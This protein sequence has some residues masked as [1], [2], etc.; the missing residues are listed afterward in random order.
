MKKQQLSFIGD[1]LTVSYPSIGKTFV[2]D[3]SKYPASVYVRCDSSE[4]GIKQKFGDAKSGGTAAEKYAEVQLIH[5]SLLAGEWERTASPDHSGIIKEAVA[6]LMKVAIGKV[7]ASLAKIKDE[8]DR[9]AKVKEWGSDLK[10]K[11][12]VAKI[13]AERAAAVADDSDDEP[14]ITL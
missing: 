9:A 8:D 5:A 6:R 11:A 2:T 10:V 4:H 1:T 13:R 14:T 12:E 7:E 3:C